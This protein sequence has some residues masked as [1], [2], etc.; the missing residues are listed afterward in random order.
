[1]EKEDLLKGVEDMKE[2]LV[3]SRNGADMRP[4]GGSVDCVVFTMSFFIKD[5]QT[6]NSEDKHLP[7]AY[8]ADKRITRPRDVWLHNLRTIL[9]L[10]IDAE[11]EWMN[12][13]PKV[14]I[15][16]PNPA[17]HP[18]LLYIRTIASNSSTLLQSLEIVSFCLCN[19]AAP[20]SNSRSISWRNCIS[21][22]A[23]SSRLS[24][25]INFRIVVARPDS[26]SRPRLTASLK[27]PGVGDVSSSFNG[28]CSNPVLV[29][30]TL[31]SHESE[32]KSDPVRLFSVSLK[33]W[34]D[35]A[36]VGLL[37]DFLDG[38]SCGTIV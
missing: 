18:M 14:S 32:V 3:G 11:G 31:F 30:P 19:L 6:Y 13:L 27:G 2:R 29:L 20:T 26:I 1:M 36:R 8:M 28:R 35:A 12:K 5:P 24:K 37:A 38:M 21:V 16:I 4:L 22:E 25:R 23:L 15:L 10:D 17:S 9:D 33:R 34:A 7:K